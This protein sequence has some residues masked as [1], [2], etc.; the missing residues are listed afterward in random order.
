[1]QSGSG[2]V[3]FLILL[4]VSAFLLA[5]VN[6]AKP[7]SNFSNGK[8]E[9]EKCPSDLPRILAPSV[10]AICSCVICLCGASWAW[11]TATTSTGIPAIQSAS[12]KLL[13]QVSEDSNTAEPEN[14]A[15]TELEGSGAAEL[16]ESSEAKPQN[17]AE[18]ELAES[19]SNYTLTSNACVI[20]L[21][22]TGTAGATGY[23]SI[24]IGD[25]IYYTEQI[26]V[27]DTGKFTFT[28]AAAANTK[29]TLTPKWGSLAVSDDINMIENDDVITATGS[30]QS[31]AQTPDSSTAI[32][33]ID[34]PADLADSTTATS[35]P[36]ESEPAL[37]ESSA[38]TSEPAE[39]A[40][41]PAE[42]ESSADTSSSSTTEG[43]AS[44]SSEL[45]E[46]ESEPTL[47]DSESTTDTESL[48]VPEDTA[49]ALSEPADSTSDSTE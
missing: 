35:T 39:S 14:F 32:E 23:C 8:E 34:D 48:S 28:V 18:T 9:N 25:K 10:L 5:A 3:I 47:A 49:S 38:A 16:S 17:S 19:G 27:K 12:Y 42:S 37:S 46:S 43:T 45:T 6:F 36:A 22:A 7:A 44:S 15:A 41:E 21:K 4:L 1:M 2:A 40:A 20:T 33:P 29:I 13:Y 11:F 31:D 26:F 30:Q 24:Q